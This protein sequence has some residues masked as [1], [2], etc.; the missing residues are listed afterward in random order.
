VKHPVLRVRKGVPLYDDAP[1]DLPTPD[2]KPAVPA[3]SRRKRRR[4]GRLIFF[5]LMVIALVVAGLT[6]WAPS[7]GTARFPGWQARLEASA[8]GERIVVAVTFTARGGAG[9]VS[10]ARVHASLPDTGDA[11]DFAGAIESPAAT[12][13]GELPLPSSVKSLRADITVDGV[14][15]TIVLTQR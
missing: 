14:S 4:R 15:R 3:P 6:L 9:R 8:S 1:P 2:P 12:L 11:V 5:P 10:Q 13:S 7:P